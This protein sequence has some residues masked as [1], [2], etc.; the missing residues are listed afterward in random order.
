MNHRWHSPPNNTGSQTFCPNTALVVSIINTKILIISLCY[1]YQY[2]IPHPFGRNKGK[3]PCYFSNFSEILW[4]V[5]DHVH[6]AYMRFIYINFQI[7]EN[8]KLAEVFILDLYSFA[9]ITRN[10]CLHF[11]PWNDKIY[12]YYGLK[13]I[14]HLKYKKITGSLHTVFFL[15]SIIMEILM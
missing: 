9:F 13:Y 4:N 12:G 2:V 5:Y 6:Y 1:H 11:T 7:S 3:Q 8:N 10:Y 14:F 15:L